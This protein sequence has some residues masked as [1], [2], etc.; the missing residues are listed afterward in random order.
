MDLNEF[1]F[2]PMKYILRCQSALSMYMFAVEAGDFEKA[3]FYMFLQRKELTKTEKEEYPEWTSFVADRRICII[4][5]DTPEIRGAVLTPCRHLFC[6]NCL[7][8]WLKVHLNCPYCRAHVCEYTLPRIVIEE[9]N[10]LVQKFCNVPAPVCTRFWK[11]QA[12]IF[13]KMVLRNDVW[14]NN[15]H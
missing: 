12:Y 11:Y 9:K 13:R 7:N 2:H 5:F 14:R 4:C 1:K 15:F 3:F 6:Q 8:K 10:R